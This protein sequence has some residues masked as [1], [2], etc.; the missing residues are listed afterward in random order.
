MFKKVIPQIGLKSRLK[1]FQFIFI[2]VACA[3]I[4]KTYIFYNTDIEYEKLMP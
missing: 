3:Y 1:E 4:D 2:H